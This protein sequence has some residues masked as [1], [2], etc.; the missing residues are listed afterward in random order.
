MAAF[1][2]LRLCDLFLRFVHGG[3]GLWVVGVLLEL[4]HGREP[5]RHDGTDVP[6]RILGLLVEHLKCS[7]TTCMTERSA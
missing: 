3:Q 1:G 2:E 7:T 4:P 6:N 5:L